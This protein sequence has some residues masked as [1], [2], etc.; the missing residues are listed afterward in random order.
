MR[1]KE[2]SFSLIISKNM[3]Y[4]CLYYCNL[5]LET[6]VFSLFIILIP[7]ILLLILPL[8]LLPGPGNCLLPLPH[9][10]VS[11][12]HH[13]RHLRPVPGLLQ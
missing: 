3:F 7:V 6:T 9:H 8:L 5:Q 13:Q 12:L 1:H 10:V 11:L 2:K 4:T